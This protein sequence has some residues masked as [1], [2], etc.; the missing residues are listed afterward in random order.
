MYDINLG[1]Q[2]GKFGSLETI[3][4]FSN[5]KDLPGKPYEHLRGERIDFKRTLTEENET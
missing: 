2:G 1:T 5:L 3:S 4:E